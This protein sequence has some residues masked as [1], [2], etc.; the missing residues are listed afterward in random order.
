MLLALR[1]NMRQD[2]L[3]GLRWEDVS[4]DYV[5]LHDTKNGS[6]RDVPLSAK[7]RRLL[8]KMR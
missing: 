8:E 6:A 2:E 3:A 1:T 7:A 5:R 4:T